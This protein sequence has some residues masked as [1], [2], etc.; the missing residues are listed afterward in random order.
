MCNA[1]VHELSGSGNRR[2]IKREF[3][4]LEQ[5]KVTGSA[6]LGSLLDPTIKGGDVAARNNAGDVAPATHITSLYDENDTK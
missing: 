6:N 2:T 4:K 3:W 5:A 1:S